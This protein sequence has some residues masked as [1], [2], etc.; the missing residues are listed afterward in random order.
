MDMTSNPLAKMKA[1]LEAR[2]KAEPTNAD[3]WRE[4]AQVKMMAGDAEGA[5]NDCIESLRIDPK[6]AAALVLMGNLLTNMRG[7]DAAAEQYYVRAV[8]ADDGF[9]SAHANYGTL[10]LKRGE[11]M[12][13]VTELRRSVELDGRQA[14]PRYMLAQA[15]IAISDW[16]SAWLVAKETLERG[17]VSFEDSANLPRVRDGLRAILDRAASKGGAEAPKTDD[18]ALEQTIRQGKFDAAH[19]D[20]DPARNL[21]MAMYMLDAMKRFE[22]MGPDK[23]RNAAM[24][25]AILG[26]HGIDPARTGGYTLKTIP[27]EDFSGYRLLAHYYVSWKMAFPD[28]L[29][30]IGLPFDDAYAIAVQMRGR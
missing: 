19:A 16:H 2:V 11:K 14:V 4:L 30:D 20:N 15:Y 10:L 12:K 5:E 29:K 25:I 24:E 28:H 3:A 9:A 21:M 1:V 26:T 18:I 6:N 13:A 27:G 22:S 17:E 8:E 7:D 23:V